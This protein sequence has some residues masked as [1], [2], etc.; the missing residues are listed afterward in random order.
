[1]DPKNPIST[2]RKFTTDTTSNQLSTNIYGCDP[3][4]VK[5]ER[6]AYQRTAYTKTAG[7]AAII[8]QR[9]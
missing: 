5:K 3:T 7:S 2:R 4:R 1:M 6:A 9:I 8:D